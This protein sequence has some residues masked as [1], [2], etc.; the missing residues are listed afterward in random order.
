MFSL[1]FWGRLQWLNDRRHHAARDQ[2]SGRFSTLEWTEDVD[3]DLEDSDSAGQKTSDPLKMSSTLYTK[4]TIDTVN[5]LDPRQIP[6]DLVVRIL[7]RLCFESAEHAD[8]SHAVL[9][10]LPGLQEIRKM[11]DAL[12]DHGVFGNPN[13]FRLFPLHSTISSEGQS[14]V[15]DIPPQGVRKIVMGESRGTFC[16]NAANSGSPGAATNIAGA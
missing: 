14:A 12:V 1:C 15:F 9:I 16:S 8:Y 7:E 11:H 3:E 4:Q 2:R 6:Y 5:L 13:A 10:F